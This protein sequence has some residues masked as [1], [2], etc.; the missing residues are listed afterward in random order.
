M[1]DL[2]HKC[3]FAHRNIATD[4][5]GQ[6]LN[7]VGYFHSLLSMQAETE[8]KNNVV[9]EIS[10]DIQREKI[11][12]DILQLN[13]TTS[14]FRHMSLYPRRSVLLKRSFTFVIL[15]KLSSIVPGSLRV[16]FG[17][18]ED[19][20]SVKNISWRPS[21]L[22]RGSVHGFS[23][24]A[25]INIL[26]RHLLTSCHLRGRAAVSTYS[27]KHQ[28]RIDIKQVGR[29]RR[30]EA[31]ELNREWRCNAPDQLGTS[32]LGRTAHPRRGVDCQY[33]CVCILCVNMNRSWIYS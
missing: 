3:E 16:S 19:D 23:M 7:A 25:C 11:M 28:N 18:G 17:G 12:W 20:E 22:L 32:D 10:W 15:K 14:R 5:Q 26:S 21:S 30:G 33:T 9:M 2:P 4:G 13:M 1:W 6:N 31:P 29:K 8:I 27:S 24:S